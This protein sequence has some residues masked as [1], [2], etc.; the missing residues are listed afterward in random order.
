MGSRDKR[1]DEYIAKSAPF[2]RPVLMRIREVVHRACPEIEEEIK[3]GVPYFNYKGLVC[4]M[5]AFKSHCA[6]GFWRSSLLADPDGIFERRDEKSAMGQF[7]RITSVSDLPGDRILA[8]YISN[9]VALNAQ[10]VKARRKPPA[11]RS[12]QVRTPEFM[13]AALK[14]DAAAMETYKALSPGQKRDYIEWLTEARVEVTRQR[15]LET[16]VAWLKQGKPR[17]WKYMRGKKRN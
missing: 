3:W 4:G 2:A 1:V 8:K 14:L 7:G 17:N 6:L 13:K 5:A 15:R 9:A 16:A 12:K 10:G 11:V